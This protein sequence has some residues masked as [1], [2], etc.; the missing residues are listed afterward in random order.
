MSAA[1]VT[2][3]TVLWPFKANWREPVNTSYEYKT[4]IFA[5]TSGKEQ[6]RAIRI[7]P[8]FSLDFLS[9]AMDP[10]TQQQLDRFVFENQNAAML[11][12]DF[13]RVRR[14]EVTSGNLVFDGSAPWAVSGAPI[15][16]VSDTG[17]EVRRVTAI[18]AGAAVLSTPAT[19]TGVI[20]VYPLSLGRLATTLQANQVTAGVK[21]L[22]VNFDGLPGFQIP[23]YP[24]VAGES[25]DG[26]EVFMFG[27][28]WKS[29]S[30]T[31]EADRTDVDYGK[32]RIASFTPI[33]FRTRV[34][35]QSFLL[36][37]RE[38]L[39]AL[40]GFFFRRLGRLKEF[41]APT[42]ADD[43][44]LIRVEGAKIVFQATG[45]VA[46]ATN[47]VDRAIAIFFEDGTHAFHSVTALEQVA[48]E[49]LL[50]VDPAPSLAVAPATVVK[51]SWM[52]LCRFAG[53]QLN[54]THRT[55]EVST[56]DLNIQTL[57]YRAASA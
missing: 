31:F 55:A 13:A 16:L 2:L 21:E 38:E 9:S 22:R 5:S 17:R 43:L 52:P 23:V 29:R 28:D 20:R 32:G 41:F 18:I 49:L 39:E 15:L 25:F 11:V 48:G 57:E 34:Y 44:T 24:G 36:K 37:S 50:T 35:K 30:H 3:G 33:K 12:P 46:L 54:I 56:V 40:S 19:L 26:R 45:Q 53:D 7:Q 4:T 14:A 6:R 1:E 27:A 42:D 47:T 8:R 51:V 10:N